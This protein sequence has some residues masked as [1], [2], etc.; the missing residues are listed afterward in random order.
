M[1]DLRELN[2]NEGGRQV[3][4]PVPTD[5][6]F[7][8]FESQTG[9]VMPV[10][11]RQL[12]EHS[13]GGHPELDSPEGALGQFSINRFFH[14]TTDDYGSESLWYAVKH[15]QPILGRESLPFANDGGGN[16]FFLDLASKPPSV[17]LCLHDELM[18]IVEIAPTFEDFINSLSIDPDM[19]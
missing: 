5:A 13:N 8:R 12:L 9:C 6:L 15:W 7:A 10:G 19:I 4:R 1:R 14:L 16:Q 17:K 18:K 2:I 11:L 3:R